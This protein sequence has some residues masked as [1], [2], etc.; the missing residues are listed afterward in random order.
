MR[1]SHANKLATGETTTGSSSEET[2]T[3]SDSDNQDDAA[4][5]LGSSHVT[6]VVAAVALLG[7]F[8]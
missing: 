6:L 2:T 8:L 5:R 7:Y 3:S 4:V 1:L